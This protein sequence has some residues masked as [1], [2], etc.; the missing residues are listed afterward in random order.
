MKLKNSTLHP[1]RNCACEK[2][3]DQSSINIRSTA[4]NLHDTSKFV[5]PS[6]NDLLG[7][8]FK[9]QVTSKKHDTTS[10]Q[11]TPTQVV[12]EDIIFDVECNLV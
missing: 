5:D 6:E 9:S 3:G 7:V 2:E 10:S 11:T 8:Q 12:G 1:N 4:V